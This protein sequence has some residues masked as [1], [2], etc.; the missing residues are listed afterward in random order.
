MSGIITAGDVNF[1]LGI[2]VSESEHANP[3]F[4]NLYSAVTQLN[5]FKNFASKYGFHITTLVN[6][7]ATIDAI[8]DYFTETL[9]HAVRN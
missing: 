2:V 6:K 5:L 7:E 9:K 3:K 8:E 1:F 4:Q